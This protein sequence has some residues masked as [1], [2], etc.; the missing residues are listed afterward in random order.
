M[1]KNLNH[2]PDK[3]L[4]FFIIS[5]VAIGLFV[6][7]S[8]SIVKSQ[9]DFQENYHYL[10]QQIMFGVLVGALFF[11]I[12]FKI[13][14]I[15]WRRIVIVLF[16]ISLIGLSLLFLPSFGIE[17]GGATRWI[18]IGGQSFQPSEF[19]K[20]FFIMY[21]AAWLS[22]RSKN[23]NSISKTVIPFIVLN[24]AIGVLFLLQPDMGSLLIIYVCSGLLFVLSGLNLRIITALL[25]IA[26]ILVSILA[27]SSDY[28]K[29]RILSFLNPDSNPL[30]ESYQSRQA[31]IGL[32]AGG[33]FGRGYGQ[34]IQKTGYLPESIGDSIF[35]ILVE[36]LGMVGGISLIIIFLAIGFRG[37]NVAKM[38]PDEF[39]RLLS[40]GITLLIV[41][42]ALINIMA[43][44]GLVPLTG[45]TLPL[46]SHGSSSYIASLFGL[47]VLMNIST[48]TQ[49]T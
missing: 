43:I 5:L 11:F 10:K 29:D 2:K 48:H 20:I 49:K 45:L 14:Y 17:R 41:C 32:G 42:Q 36:E 13:K 12:G 30:D 21:I 1:K 27:I 24:G 33:V 8:A 23:I 3:L 15:F 25:I 39:S 9:G 38:A 34:G 37:F 16:L 26:I 19:V 31:L 40:A 7:A 46:V 47:G 22:G 4:L 18:N 6:L 44:S 35:V 28:R